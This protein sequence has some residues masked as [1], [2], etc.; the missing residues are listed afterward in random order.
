MIIGVKIPQTTFMK[1]SKCSVLAAKAKTRAAI[2]AKAQLLRERNVD[3]SEIQEISLFADVLEKNLIPKC[4]RRSAEDAE[5]RWR[6]KKA[7]F[8]TSKK[9]I[10]MKIGS[11]QLWH[12]EN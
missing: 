6:S 7:T 4:K 3:T 9:Q 1:L 12:K 2:E 11:F 5:A 8:G 10:L